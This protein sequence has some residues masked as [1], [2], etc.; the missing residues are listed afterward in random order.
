MSGMIEHFIEYCV[1]GAGLTTGVLVV[2]VV[3]FLLILILLFLWALVSI[4]IEHVNGRRRKKR[5]EELEADFPKG[6]K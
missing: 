2:C 1:I 6:E 5:I 3:I 4:L